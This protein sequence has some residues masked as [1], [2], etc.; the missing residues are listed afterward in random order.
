LPSSTI[1]TTTTSHEMVVKTLPSAQLGRVL[2]GRYT[3]EKT[4]G[5]GSFG[6]VLRALDRAN[7]ATVAVKVQQKHVKDTTMELRQRREQHLHSIVSQHPNVVSFLNSFETN[8]AACMVLQF[9]PAGDLCTAIENRAYYGDSALITHCF[10]Q[11]LDAVAFCHARGV[12]HRDLK[13]E[14]VLVSGDR[15]TWYLTDFGLAT[16]N[17]FSSSAGIGTQC[18]MAPEVVGSPEFSR[19]VIKNAS[20]DV[21]SLGMTLLA[22]VLGGIPWAR[23]ERKDKKFA[24]YVASP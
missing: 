23:A 18:Y 21:W 13:P 24:Q 5:K 11:L 12:Y 15:R 9:V 17:A 6:A 14:N 19:A 22:V 16:P 2:A 1:I 7:S 3:L 10:A 8:D 20:A 4:I